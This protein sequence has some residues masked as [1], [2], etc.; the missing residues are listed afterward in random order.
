MDEKTTLTDS[1]IFVIC[2]KSEIHVVD[3]IDVF[4]A[5]NVKSDFKMLCDGKDTLKNGF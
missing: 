5:L 2:L 4:V 1:P 3:K